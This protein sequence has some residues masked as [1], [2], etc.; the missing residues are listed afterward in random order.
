M[1]AIDDYQDYL[2]YDKQSKEYKIDTNKFLKMRDIHC[3]HTS[4]EA[5]S[6]SN[7]NNIKCRLDDIDFY[8]KFLTTQMFVEVNRFS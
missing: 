3:S 7:T 6:S 8:H 2:I 1:M 4:E 5:Q